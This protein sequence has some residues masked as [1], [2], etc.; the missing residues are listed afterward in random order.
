MLIKPPK[1]NVRI[2][3]TF[4]LGWTFLTFT[5]AYWVIDGTSVVKDLTKLFQTKVENQDES[6]K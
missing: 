5:Y 1:P 3:R 6:I 2:W 4:I